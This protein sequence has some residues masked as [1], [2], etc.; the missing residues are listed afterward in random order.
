MTELTPH[1]SL[2]IYRHALSGIASCCRR[3]SPA[4][5]STSSRGPGSSPIPKRAALLL[6]AADLY[7]A[8]ALETYRNMPGA[9][10]ERFA[11][12]AFAFENI[13]SPCTASATF[14]ASSHQRTDRLATRRDPP[15]GARRTAGHAAIL[16]RPGQWN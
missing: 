4:R 11:S 8:P 2:T 5:I 6:S 14:G 7:P 13:R 3:G 10:A 9:M 15:L 12:V 1:N 16:G